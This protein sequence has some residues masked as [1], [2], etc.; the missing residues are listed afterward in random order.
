MM[1]FNDFVQKF[2]L[3]NKAKINIK[4]Y[5]ELKKIGEDSKVGKFLSDWN[6][7]TN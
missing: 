4:I 7:S 5:E 6:F 2:C 3:K 1:K